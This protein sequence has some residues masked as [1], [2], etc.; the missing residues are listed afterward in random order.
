[1][2]VHDVDSVGK[3]VPLSEGMVITVEPG[4]YVRH[5]MDVPDRWVRPRGMMVVHHTITVIC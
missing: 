1:M 5:D 2:D 3:N 4:L